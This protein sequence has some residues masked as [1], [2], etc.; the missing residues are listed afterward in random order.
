MR[1]PFRFIALAA[2]CAA[3]VAAPLARAYDKYPSKPV[4]IIVPYAPGGPNDIVA[5]LIAAKLGE[6]E[7]QSFIVENKPGGGSN[8]GAEFVAKAGFPAGTFQMKDFRVKDSTFLALLADAQ[9]YKLKVI[10]PMF[11]RFPNRRFILIGDSGEKDP[12]IYGL[13]ARKF[14]KQVIAILIRNVTDE[15]HH[16]IRYKNVFR[17]LAPKTWTIFTH[18]NELP[19]LHLGTNK[20]P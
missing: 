6:I 9:T 2:A 20:S 8:I 14:P 12:E 16:A 3:T 4:K 19:D 11:E 1:F 15:N 13:L 18:P 5:R 7:K 10:T 17:A